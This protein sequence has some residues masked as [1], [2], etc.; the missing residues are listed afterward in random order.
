MIASLRAMSLRSLLASASAFTA[1]WMVMLS[2][3]YFSLSAADI[4]GALGI[5]SDDASWLPTAYSTFEPVGVV[6]GCWLAS[7]LSIRRVFLGG[8]YLF[9][10]ATCLALIV[11]TF[12]SLVLS[13]ALMGAAAGAI[14]PMSILVQLR[15]FGLSQRVTAIAVYACATTM[16]PQLAGAIDVWA[17]THFGWSAVLSASFGPG[18]FAL[19][20]GHNAL[21]VEPIRWR[22]LLHT[23][24]SSL[25]SL[26]SGLAL[27]A[28]AVS[29]GD[30][31]RWTQSAEIIIALIISL[32][33]L[34]YFAAREF[35][36]LRFPVLASDLLR[37]RNFSI[38]T[39]ATLPLQF[40]SMVSI[41][42]LPGLLTNVQGFRPEQIAPALSAMLL[43]QILAYALCVLALHARW[44]DAR[45]AL[46]L[47]FGLVTL[48]CFDNLQL[49]SDWIVPNLLT[50]QILQGLGL[51]F[52]IVPL[53][54]IFI[55]DVRA[56]EGVDAAS[57]FNVAR[58]LATTIASASVA[59]STR[60]N[61][62]A[63][64]SELLTSSGFLPKTQE[65]ALST[66]GRHVAQM[67]PDSAHQHVQALRIIADAAHRQAAVLSTT[68]LL[69]VLGG[70][71]LAS[72]FAVVLM[73]E[74]GS[75]HPDRHS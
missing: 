2:T 32:L 1:A 48:A 12:P 11:P 61:G 8:I 25:I 9:L 43:P 60:L 6:I 72:C 44:I 75:G 13:R 28:F 58:S 10:G 26:S 14:M 41:A 47:G 27:F 39:F 53:L 45:S 17:V 70:L 67:D 66:I 68:D 35:R 46:I 59:T 73:S 74:F 24:R 18:L 40:A 54:V 69:A 50:G 19:A 37:R 62:Q 42:V 34:G 3:R 31:L 57:I 56:D 55:G 38:S 49:T 20:T 33:C 16:G 30:R 52:I 36:T 15:V 65:A 5:G 64:Y 23:D 51:P 22:P 63:N 4:S 21:Q 7:A 71:L 29:Q